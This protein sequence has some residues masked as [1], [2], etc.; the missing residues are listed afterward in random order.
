LEQSIQ[1]QTADEK[2]RIL[3][4]LSRMNHWNR[5]DDYFERAAEGTGQ[6]FLNNLEF[7]YWLNG[8]NSLLWCPGDRIV[9][10]P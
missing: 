4:W 7:I 10:Q 8:Q 2:R 6:W 1:D 5:Q 3:N 9:P